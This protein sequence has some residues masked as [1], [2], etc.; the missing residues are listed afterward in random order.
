VGHAGDHY[1]GLIKP[2]IA[3]KLFNNLSVG[4]EH[5]VYY[6]DRYTRDYGA[7]HQVRTEQKVFLQLYFESFKKEAK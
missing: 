3:L 6:S 1:I 5:L 4:F 7:F 2:R